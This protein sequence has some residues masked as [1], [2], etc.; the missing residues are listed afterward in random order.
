MYKNIYVYFDKRIN[1]LYNF[2][3]NFYDLNLQI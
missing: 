2:L 3:Y 1:T